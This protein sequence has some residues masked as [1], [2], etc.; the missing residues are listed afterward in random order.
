LA[1]PGKYKEKKFTLSE[2][3][4]DKIYCIQHCPSLYNKDIYCLSKYKLIKVKKYDH[5]H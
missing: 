5:T 1:F 2:I 4:S 3:Q